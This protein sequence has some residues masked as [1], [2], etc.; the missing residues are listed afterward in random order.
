MREVEACINRAILWRKDFKKGNSEVVHEDGVAKVYLHRNLIIE[1]HHEGQGLDFHT[2]LSSCGWQTVTTKSR[3][4]A[5]LS[6]FFRGAYI[7]QKD[8]AWYLNYEGEDFDFE[9]GMELPLLYAKFP[10]RISEIE[11]LVAS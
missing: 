3:L 11:K 5:Y 7:Y 2:T 9:D 10:V 8:F 6:E 4:N 1:H